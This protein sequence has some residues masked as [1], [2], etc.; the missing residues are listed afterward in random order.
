MAELTIFLIDF[1]SLYQGNAFRRIPG[2]E[3]HDIIVDET[4]DCELGVNKGGKFI[5]HGITAF[6]N[7][8]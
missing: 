2:K 7:L 8:N 5:G 6:K 4:E 1:I 3:S